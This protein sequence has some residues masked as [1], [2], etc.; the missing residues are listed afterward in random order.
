MPRTP[1]FFYGLAF[2][3]S[4]MGIA[5]AKAEFVEADDLRRLITGKTIEAKT[6]KDGQAWQVQMLAHGRARFTLTDGSKR[7]ALWH[8]EGR[9]IEFIFDLTGDRTCRSILIDNQGRNHWQDCDTGVT[10]SFI[11]RPLPTPTTKISTPAERSNVEHKIEVELQSLFAQGYETWQA[12][13]L[14]QVGPASSMR[15]PLEL[16][17]GT[18]YALVA[19]C[20]GNCSHVAL[21][22][23]DSHGA[24]LAQ[25]TEQH[26][27]VILAGS[28]AHTGVHEVKVAVPGCADNKCLIGLQAL[29]LT[30]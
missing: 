21:T 10:S 7:E 18:T 17:A 19:T 22:L 8:V 26:H 6:A 11:V 16:Q 1:R 30:K 23:R 27:T 24:I 29:R 25:S 2:W 5:S 28:A 4:F 13:K 3:L 20:G 9:R 15:H 12:A 14:E